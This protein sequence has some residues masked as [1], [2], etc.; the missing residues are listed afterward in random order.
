MNKTGNTKTHIS[1]ILESIR[2]KEDVNVSDF[3]ML[4]L[5]EAKEA[6][7]AYRFYL[8]ET[9]N[10][11]EILERMYLNFYAQSKL[12]DKEILNKLRKLW[13]KPQPQKQESKTLF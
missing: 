8:W 4:M 2:N 7:Y 3:R 5:L 6:L 13:T 9:G 11:C 10:K 12:S 1:R